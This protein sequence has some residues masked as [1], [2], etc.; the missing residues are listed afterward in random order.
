MHVEDALT[1]AALKVMMMT[2]QGRLKPRSFTRQFNSSNT[3]LL[4]QQLEIAIDGGQAKS[5][6]VL[7]RALLDFERQ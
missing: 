5:R 1:H 2:V 7:L 4:H 6:H 3:A